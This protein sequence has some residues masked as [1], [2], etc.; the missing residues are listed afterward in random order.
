M[1]SKFTEKP[2]LSFRAQRGIC[3]SLVLGTITWAVVSLL[4]SG[5][6]LGKEPKRPKINGISGVTILVSDL[7]SSREKYKQIFQPNYSCEWCEEAP[8]A[9]FELGAGQT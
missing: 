9:N 5:S 8:T 3:F 2:T 7:P 1:T 4:A 6:A